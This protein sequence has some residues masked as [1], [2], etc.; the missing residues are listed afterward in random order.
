MCREIWESFKPR[1]LNVNTAEAPKENIL[2]GS[3]FFRI[4]EKLSK[5]P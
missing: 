4:S 1:L 3:Y 2:A 5:C